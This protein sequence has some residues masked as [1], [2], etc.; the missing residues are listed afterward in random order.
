M[1]VT[2]EY[3]S[4]AVPVCYFRRT[5]LAAM[6]SF[7][8]PDQKGPHKW[9]SLIQL[10]EADQPSESK[11]SSKSITNWH[12]LCTDEDGRVLPRGYPSTKRQ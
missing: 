11:F 9:I 7:L 12:G 2:V 3:G 5:K 10:A 1:H 8:R 4:T 6:A